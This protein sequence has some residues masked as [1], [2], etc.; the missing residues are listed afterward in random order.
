MSFGL[1]AKGPTSLADANGKPPDALAAD[2]AL[3]LA[4]PFGL[5]IFRGWDDLTNLALGCGRILGLTTIGADVD[6]FM[7][8][9]AFDSNGVASSSSSRARG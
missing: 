3:A 6:R 5:G 9:A 7:R 1:V 8:L 4:F 2:L